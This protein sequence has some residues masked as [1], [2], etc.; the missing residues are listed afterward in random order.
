MLV[1]FAAYKAVILSITWDEAA[2]YLQ[3]IQYGIWKP[4]S[5]GLLDANKNILNSLC[6]LIS[7][8]LL[9]AE[10]WML[11]LH[12]LASHALFLWCSAKICVRLKNPTLIVCGFLI[13]QCNPY[14]MDFFSLAR[15]YAMGLAFE[16]ASILML[17]NF[18]PKQLRFTNEFFGITESTAVFF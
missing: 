6:M 18:I 2:I 11:R 13:I 12:S 1:L 17:M 5:A 8:K 9:G 3:H 14:M 15:G 10:P 7:S 4:E 16:M